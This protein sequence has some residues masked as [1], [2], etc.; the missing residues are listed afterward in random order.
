MAHIRKLNLEE[1]SQFSCF[2]SVKMHW[3]EER[4]HDKRDCPKQVILDCFDLTYCPVVGLPCFF[5]SEFK[6]VLELQVNGCLEM[7]CLTPNLL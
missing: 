4:S 6:M 1:S 3:S 7:E 2:F 5:R